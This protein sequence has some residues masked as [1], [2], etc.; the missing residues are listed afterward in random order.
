MTGFRVGSR[1]GSWGQVGSARWVRL[2]LY[3]GTNFP[4]DCSAFSCDV[5]GVAGM[6]LTVGGGKRGGGGWLPGPAGDG[7][8]SGAGAG[9]GG[10]GGGGG[11]P[12]LEAGRT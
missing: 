10:G 4:A 2:G 7:P 1:L 12:S 11:F 8:A 9:G 3:C 5:W 6:R